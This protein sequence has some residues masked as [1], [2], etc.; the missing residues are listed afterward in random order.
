MSSFWIGWQGFQENKT[1]QKELIGYLKPIA[2]IHNKTYFGRRRDKSTLEI[3]DNEWI[4]GEILIPL[5]YF[6][7]SENLLNP[8]N[9]NH[10]NEK[11][12][13]NFIKIETIGERTY[14]IFRKVR[15]NGVQFKMNTDLGE[16]ISSKAYFSK[17]SFVFF[18]FGDN[19]GSELIKNNMIKVSVP[20]SCWEKENQ[21]LCCNS[22]Q[23][24]QPIGTGA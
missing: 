3:F 11:F 8:E 13:G 5:F 22:L 4:E 18:D 21:K 2:E 20:A 9:L 15:L 16:S 10:L 12:D 23:T 24:V 1:L 6:S 19:T 14:L 17:I 7:Q